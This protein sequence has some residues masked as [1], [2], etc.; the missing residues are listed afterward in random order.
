MMPIAQQLERVR[1]AARRLLV[2]Q[3]LCQWLAG[4]LFAALALGVIDFGLR[5]PGWLRL[6][7][8]AAALAFAALWLWNHLRA[9]L[10][11]RPG[12]AQ[13]ALR[14][15]RMYP[16]LAGQLATAVEFAAA[17]ARYRETPLSDA[18]VGRTLESAEPR[19]QH[20]E[21]SRLIDRSRTGRAAA[22]AGL[23]L[24]AVG[25]I[26]V[27]S[28]AYAS[29]A[30]RRWLQPLADVRWPLRQQ[31]VSATSE[32]V[33]PADAP[34]RLGAHV[35][36]GYERGMRVTLHYRVETPDDPAGRDG[37]GWQSVLMSEQAA[38]GLFERQ[39]DLPESLV[40]GLERSGGAATLRYS[41]EAG[42]HATPEHELTIVPRPEVTSVAAQVTPP[43]Y[44]A[45]YV[46]PQRVDLGG[47]SESPLATLAVLA[48][49]TVELSIKANKPDARIEADGGLPADYGRFTLASTL[50]FPIRLRDQHGLTN[51]S[52]RRYRVEAVEDKPAAISLTQPAVDEAVL[53]TATVTLEAAASD[54]VA[55]RR[56]AI[57]VVRQR[58]REEAAEAAAAVPMILGERAPERPEATVVETLDLGSAFPGTDALAPGDTLVITGVAEDVFA[59]DGLTHPAVRS[60]PRRLRVIDEASLVGQLR[61]DLA[62]VR[63]QA[64]RLQS[65]QDGLAERGLDTQGPG[66]EVEGRLERAATA[67]ADLS[68]RIAAQ[69][70]VV[71][72]L[73][74]R[75]QRNRLDEPAL[76][77]LMNQAGELLRRASEA[78]DA[79][80]GDI[81]E[82][83]EAKGREEAMRSSSSPQEP[84]PDP[85]AAADEAGR[86]QEAAEA[87]LGEL[88]ALLD[89]GGDALS[90]Q[91][92]LRQLQ[93]AQENLAQEARELFPRTVGQDPQKLPQET[94]DRLANLAQKQGDLAEQ[95]RSAVSQMQDAAVRL[96]DQKEDDGAQASAEALAEAAA[97][98]QRQG[99]Q[100]NMQQA[101]QSAGQNQL[102]Q[103][104][105]SQG[106]AM[107]TLSQM[108]EQMGKGQER[109][110]ARLRRKLQQLA[111]AI[112]LALERQRA[113]V[114]QLDQVADDAA[115]STLEP[116]LAA[117]R[118]TTMAIEE[119]AKTARGAEA[120]AG[121]LAQAVEAQGRAVLALRAAQRTPAKESEASAVTALERALDAVRA[122]EREAAEQQAKEKRQE[123]REKYEALAARQEDLRKKVGEARGDAADGRPLTRQQRAAIVPSATAQDE[124]R[125]DA[126]K[127]MAEAVESGGGVVFEHMHDRLETSLQGVTR[128]LRAGDA[129]TALLRSQEGAA[130]TLRQ[131]AAA[132]GDDAGDDPFAGGEESGEGGGGGGG[133]GPQPIPP[134]A[135]LKLLRSAQDAVYQATRAAADSG[136]RPA[137]AE[138]GG[139]QRELAELGRRMVEKLQQG[140][141]AQQQTAPA[142]EEAEVTP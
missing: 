53:P 26:A 87:R 124:V 77:E 96:R 62:A 63:Q 140:P 1:A 111:E 46:E 37:G 114:A 10:S 102:S 137:A 131:M 93:A 84:R 22:V 103:A 126:G 19:L 14:L 40:R 16:Q 6:G 69:R 12:L 130:R 129:D 42:D 110:M 128:R 101:A 31:V 79:A 78:S 90:L 123:L 43:A 118:R 138:L 115:L 59:L 119:Q 107:Q 100:Q 49:S 55:L 25:A 106:Q 73:Q 135:E 72:S 20:V 105:G 75:A 136:D 56:A 134:A 116:E 82:A 108:L 76:G 23:A 92:A 112:E 97:I 47:A 38:R 83:R 122:M 127:L 61:A 74:G 15:E 36:K 86:Q 81:R 7:I 3:R 120:A 9:A 99:L 8:G 91:V 58:P 85:Q 70:Q 29:I 132:L 33:W 64:I 68:R 54:D 95:A 18:M 51:L 117:L 57:E 98:A 133:Q 65:A 35:E 44:A 104:Q 67:Q 139:Q 94:K 60:A 142:P 121:A 24:V 80:A 27:A 2:A 141:E 45:P 34:V 5:L 13:L 39:V 32:S 17:P 41:F 11:F 66:G 109:M 89:Q 21:V 71:S 48:G 50:E 30:A 52:E 113:E 28:P 4:L 125:A 88:V